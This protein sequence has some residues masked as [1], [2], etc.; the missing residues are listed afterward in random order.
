MKLDID[1][2]RQM[3]TVNGIGIS[4]DLLNQM[5]NPDETKLFRFAKRGLGVHIS[6]YVSLTEYVPGGMTQ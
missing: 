2:E 4:F 1:T 3:I 5:T 6:A